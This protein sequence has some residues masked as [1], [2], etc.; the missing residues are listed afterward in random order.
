MTF[1]ITNEH[2][3]YKN[4]GWILFSVVNPLSYIMTAFIFKKPSETITLKLANSMKLLEKYF[5][6]W[7]IKLNIDKTQARIKITNFSRSG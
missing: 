5:Y 2:W 7:N 3:T 6:E 4:C 1:K